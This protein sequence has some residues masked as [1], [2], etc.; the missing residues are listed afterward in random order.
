MAFQAT[1]LYILSELLTSENILCFIPL[2]PNNLC[3]RI[4]LCKIFCRIAVIL[5]NATDVAIGVKSIF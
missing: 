4:V 1:D 5:Y 3:S 2:C